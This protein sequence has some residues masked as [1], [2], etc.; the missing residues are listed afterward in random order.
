MAMQIN[1]Q[2]VTADYQAGPIRSPEILKSI[3]TT[4]KSGSFTAVVGQT[5]S[6]K[7]SLLKLMNGLLLPKKGEVAVGEVTI[8][9]ENAKQ[10]VKE[11]RRK[12]GMVFQFPESQLFAET[13]E[14]D[15]MFGPMNFGV[16]EAEAK[17]IALEVIGRVGLD[18]S[19]LSKSPFSLS[20]GQKRYVAMAG[21]LAMRPDILV[22]DEPDAGLDPK[23]KKE[24]MDL[25][26]AWHKERG[27]TTLLVTHDMDDAAYYADEVVVMEEGRIVFQ[28]E[29]E[30]LFAD[31]SAVHQWGLELP[32]A[33]KLQ[34]KLEQEAGVTLPQVCLTLDQL[35]D[36]L[37]EAGLA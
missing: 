8:T 2:E 15:I 10:S 18:A 23:G 33:R 9:L 12:V 13:V 16:P 1:L 34:V 22:L 28:G 31:V 36:A 17:E 20:G 14:K 24:V 35:A 4:I 5:G 3:S 27:L 11:A 30:Q 19:I 37:V 32:Q 7:S 29:P 26:H 25:I 6:G 21:I